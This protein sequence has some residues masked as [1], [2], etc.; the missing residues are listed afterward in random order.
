M[1]VAFDALSSP[2]LIDFDAMQELTVIFDEIDTDKS[3]L[4]DFDEFVTGVAKF[5]LEKAPNGNHRYT[6]VNAQRVIL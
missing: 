2:C 6:A 3:G 5:V 1:S 4:I